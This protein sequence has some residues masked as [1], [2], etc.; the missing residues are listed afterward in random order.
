MSS[1]YLFLVIDG[2]GDRP[3]PGLSNRTPLQ[4]ASTPGLDAWATGGLSG[5]V[6]P[7][8]SGVVPNTHSGTGVLLGLY[9]DQFGDLRRGPIEAAGAG[10]SLSAG[11]VAFRANFATLEERDG[12]LQVIDRRARRITGDTEQLASTGWP[13]PGGWG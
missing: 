1:G 10:V 11:D 8:E 3:Q 9:P 6:D 4:A 7:I 12:G 5:L 13:G 2:L